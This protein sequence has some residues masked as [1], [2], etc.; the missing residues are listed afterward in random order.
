IWPMVAP[1]LSDRSRGV[2]IRA[3][4][5]LAAVPTSR[6]PS[7]DRAAFDQAAADFVAA[8]QSNAD[9]PEAHSTLGNFYARPGL[10]GEAWNGYRAALQLSRE[11]APAV[12]N[13][14]DLYRQLGRDSDGESV[15]RTAVA[16]SRQEAGL[17]YTLGLN[18]TR[19]K[20]PDAALAEL[21][22]A[23]EIEPDR[24]RY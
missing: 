16:S 9:R 19:Q 12:I 17:H 22:T 18:L 20:R 2:R 14:A 1:F 13:L 8:Q 6:Q 7:S 15:L 11:Y 10:R 21:R 4:S 3:V 23:T 5:V 24:S